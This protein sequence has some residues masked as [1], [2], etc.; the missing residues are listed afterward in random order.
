VHHQ[1]YFGRHE[2]HYF[3][4]SW[5]DRQPWT[6]VQRCLCIILVNVF[7][8]YNFRLLDYFIPVTNP[9]AR[10]ICMPRIYIWQIIFL[11]LI[12]WY[13]FICLFHYIWL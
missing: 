9:H 12:I 8:L 10:T 13:M 5:Q 1:P 7:T 4:F 6:I 11:Y 3:A 2:S